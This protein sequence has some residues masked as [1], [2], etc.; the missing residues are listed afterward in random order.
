MKFLLSVLMLL[1]YTFDISAQEVS[2]LY[3]P[4]LESLAVKNRPFD[5]DFKDYTITNSHVSK[6]SKLTHFYLNQRFQG[7]EIKNAVIS[8][9]I[10]AEGKLV[11]LNHQFLLDLASRVSGN[12]PVISALDAI[13]RAAKKLNYD[14]TIVPELLEERGGPSM[15]QIFSKA[16]ISQTDIPSTIILL[17]FS[18]VLMLISLASLGTTTPIIVGVICIVL[19]SIV[20]I[21]IVPFDKFY[22]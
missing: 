5:D 21:F 7:I 17:L 14:L 9:H 20:F 10:D 15:F 11:K 2:K 18:S 8:I 6:R 13:K 1:F 4:N 3:L 12:H 22:Y 16:G 19:F